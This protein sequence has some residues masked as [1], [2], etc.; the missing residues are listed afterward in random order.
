MGNTVVTR[1]CEVYNSR[2]G[3]L[4]QGG[5]HWAYKHGPLGQDGE[6]NLRVTDRT[7]D[8][9]CTRLKIWYR[10]PS[11]DNMPETRVWRYCN[12]RTGDIRATLNQGQTGAGPGAPDGGSFPVYKKGYYSVW[13]CSG[14]MHRSCIRLWQQ[15]VAQAKDPTD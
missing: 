4:V 7:A 15:N 14:K 3:G 11:G 8:D 9:K 5:I 10:D 1:D 12:G 2:I 6:V 13:H